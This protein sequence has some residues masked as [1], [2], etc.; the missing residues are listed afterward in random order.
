MIDSLLHICFRG[1]F[2]RLE[3]EVRVC[4]ALA[5]VSASSCEWFLEKPLWLYHVLEPWTEHGGWRIRS[6]ADPESAPRV[7]YREGPRGQ[8][9]V[10]HHRED[11]GEQ[12]VD[13]GAFL[14]TECR[15]KSLLF[16]FSTTGDSQM[17]S[18]YLLLIYLGR[19]VGFLQ[20]L[21]HM[22]CVS[23]Q[24][25]SKCL[26]DGA[27]EYLQMLSLCSVIM[28]Q[29]SQSW[30]KPSREHG[31]E[32]G[33]QRTWVDPGPRRSS[34]GSQTRLVERGAAGLGRR[35]TSTRH[36]GIFSTLLNPLRLC[37]LPS[38]CSDK[39]SGQ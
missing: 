5:S 15:E 10:S 37:F 36:R 21:I 20:D 1:T 8:A 2:E 27:D 24:V 32:H 6:H 14:A 25:V 33:G 29:S 28:Q 23:V 26:S 35:G 39:Y 38:N 9:E 18:F 19:R 30:S 31:H 13:S 16:S 7:H 4:A 34:R 11:G 12:L 17:C 3:V 22:F